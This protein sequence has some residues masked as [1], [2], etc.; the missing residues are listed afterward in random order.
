MPSIHPAY[1][2]FICAHVEREGI[3]LE[4]LFEQVSLDW[5]T[6]IS[7]QRFLSLEQ[8][9]GVYQRACELTQNPMLVL[10]VV[11]INDIS[12]HGPLGYGSLA[13]KDI[14]SALTLVSQM[15]PTRI[16]LYDTKVNVSRESVSGE[17]FEM[18]LIEQFDIGDASLFFEPAFIG[19]F[20][21]FIKK[22]SGLNPFE[23]SE[24]LNVCFSIE[25]PVWAEQ[26]R[27]LYPNLSISFGHTNFKLSVEKSLL[28][29]PCL[30]ADEFAYRNAQRE[31]EALLS[32]F[33]KEGSTTQIVHR[34]LIESEHTFPTAEQMANELNISTRTLNRRLQSEGGNYQSL[35]D[36]VR[37]D[38]A[39][40]LLINSELS[41]ENIAS[42]LGYQDTSNFARVFR[43]WF[44]ITPNDFRT[45]NS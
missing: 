1:L 7:R 41:I 29:K 33:S 38:K 32:S 34:R 23:L 37:K 43:R 22:V 21:D 26:L 13:A 39:T 20:Y 42:E 35:L 31:C 36:E 11:S 2:R 24:R 16:A 12:S 45:R 14:G 44:A 30:T 19:S 5:E 40:W 8:F 9:M 4:K 18:D 15:L 27:N 28:S 25:P 3:C 6:L 10:D 17:V